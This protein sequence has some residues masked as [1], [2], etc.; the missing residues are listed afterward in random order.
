[1]YFGVMPSTVPFRKMFS[2]AVRSKSNPA[3]SSMS[4]AMVP[5]TVTLPAEGLNTPD[6]TFRRVD[7][8]EP[9]SPTRP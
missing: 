8:P 7:L 2:R 4:G 5:R 9:F 1:M 6:I 3:P